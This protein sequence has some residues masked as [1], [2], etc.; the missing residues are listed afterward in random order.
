[1]DEKCSLYITTRMILTDIR[2][3]EECRSGNL[4][5]FRKLIDST[6]PFAFSVAFRILGNEEKSR[7]VVQEAMITI[8]QKLRKIRNVEAYT[9]WVYRIVV[10]QCY[11]E[12][13]KQKHVPEYSADEKTW[14]L[15]AETIGEDF[16]GKLENEEI[17]KIVNVL[18]EKLTPRQKTV[19]VLSEIE[20]LTPDEIAEIT[21]MSKS[22]IKA[23]LYYAR[24]NI[25]EM[26]IKYL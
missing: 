3:I 5:S 22:L 20:Q 23:N 4:E 2:L 26:L 16:S 24:K 1:L 6:T 9:T 19:F 25:G 21:G 13:R 10:N 14:K 7:D 15:L 18:T 12:L 8:W 11:D 17:A